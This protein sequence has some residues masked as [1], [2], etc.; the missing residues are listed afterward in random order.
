MTLLK[1][2]FFFLLLCMLLLPFVIYKT[3]WLVA[4]V[5]TQGTMC[6][7]GKNLNGQFSSTYPVIKFR[8]EKGDTIFFNG[9]NE[10]EYKI[11]A[12]VPVRYQRTN[13]SDARINGFAAIWQ[14]AII[15][16]LVPVLVLLLVFV[17]PGIIQ[18]QSK[19]II[20]KKALVKVIHGK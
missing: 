13:P 17:H 20:G 16:A 3:V 18:R 14:D 6:F 15:Y 2:Q 19:I 7:M 4:S 12:Q 11:G 1:W 9:L 5:P 8:T 10:A